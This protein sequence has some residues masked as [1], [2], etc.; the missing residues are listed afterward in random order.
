M[1]MNRMEKHFV[2]DLFKIFCIGLILLGA[3]FSYAYA[4]RHADHECN[5]EHCSICQSISFSLNREN[6]R[7]LPL[8]IGTFAMAFV[9]LFSGAVFLCPKKTDLTQRALVHV[10]MND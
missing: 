3:L 10:R 9:F 1:I 6:R 5:H 2:R 8:Q 4:A 7:A